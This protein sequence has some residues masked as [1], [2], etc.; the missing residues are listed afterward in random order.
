MQFCHPAFVPVVRPIST[1]RISHHWFWQSTF[2]LI[3]SSTASATSASRKSC[4]KNGDASRPWQACHLQWGQKQV[5]QLWTWH[6]NHNPERTKLPKSHNLWS[7]LSK[8]VYDIREAVPCREFIDLS[9]DNVYS[10]SNKGAIYID[11]CPFGLTTFAAAGPRLWNFFRS[12]CAF[13]TSYRDCSDDIWRYTLSASMHA[14]LLD[15]WY[16]APQKNTYLLTV[17]Q[18]VRPCT[19][20]DTVYFPLFNDFGCC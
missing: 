9:F 2:R 7:R 13:Q 20:A 18:P 5:Q 3:S 15:F 19:G 14:A 10:L 12:S 17:C 1:S 16:A 11:T 4:Y 8:L 6:R